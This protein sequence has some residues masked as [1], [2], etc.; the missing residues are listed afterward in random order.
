MFHCKKYF[1]IIFRFCS[2]SSIVL[3]ELKKKISIVNPQPQGFIVLS[4]LWNLKHFWANLCFNSLNFIFIICCCFLFFFSYI[5]R[6]PTRTYIHTHA[7]FDANATHISMHKHRHMYIVAMYLWISLTFE[8]LMANN[9]W[10]FK[11]ELFIV[12]K[13][14]FC[15]YAYQ[16]LYNKHTYIYYIYIHFY[17]YELL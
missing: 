12:L 5:Q 16:C 6:L 2:Y 7:Y 10:K 11:F 13:P 3:P 14:S 8:N 15:Y 1:W 4:L 9:Y 17:K